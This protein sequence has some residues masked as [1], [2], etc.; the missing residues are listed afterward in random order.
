M[1]TQRRAYDHARLHEFRRPGK[2]RYV[3]TNKSALIISRCYN[4]H[5]DDLM[6]KT[7]YLNRF[8]AGFPS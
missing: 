1:N 7:G 3:A 6:F 8:W 4:D 2:C 5:I